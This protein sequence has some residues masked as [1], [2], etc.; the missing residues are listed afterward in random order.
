[1]V[2]GGFCGC[3]VGGVGGGVEVV[4]RGAVGARGLCG[5]WCGRFYCRALSLDFSYQ[6]LDRVYLDY[7][8]IRP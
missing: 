1:M 3:L 4:D 6:Y 5:T 2:G 8:L 7:T